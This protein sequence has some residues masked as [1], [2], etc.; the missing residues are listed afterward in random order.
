MMILREILPLTFC[1][2]DNEDVCEDASVMILV[3]FELPI[4]LSIKN[5]NIP[6]WVVV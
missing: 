6:T 1:S 4:Y 3:E 5:R 2:I